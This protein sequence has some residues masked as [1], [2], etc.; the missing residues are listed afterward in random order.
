MHLAPHIASLGTETA[1]E[2]L[3][4]A[5]ALAARGRSVINLGIGQSDFPT[6]QHI[7][8]AGCRAL[9]DGHHGYTPANGILPLREAIAAD[10]HR[11]FGA[12][13]DPAQ[14]V[15]APGGKVTLAFALMMLG[16]PGVEVLTPDP[17]Y[18][19]Y[20]SMIDFSGATA[21]GYPPGGAGC[22]AFSADAILSR[23][24][25]RTRLLILNSPSN[26][27][28]EV[29]PRDELDRLVLGL[30]RHPNVYVLSDEIYSRLVFGRARHTSLLE[31]ES[32]RDRVI[33]LDGLS[34]TYAMSGWRVGWGIW[35]GNLA[36]VAARLAINIYSC[37][38][39]SA[40]HAGIAALQ[41]PQDDIARMVDTFAARREVLVPALDRLPGLS[42]K[43]PDG[44][45]FAF[46]DI[47]ATGFSA[48]ELQDRWLEELGVAVLAG[49]SFGSG[50]EGHVRISYASS[51]DELREALRRIAGW[52]DAHG[53][54]PLRS[55]A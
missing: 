15:V 49:T 20:R 46:P 11:R 43:R 25:A 40:Q 17:G 54:A 13:V 47:R 33:V 23:I 26:P 27:T 18:P 12:R 24:T 32:L 44:A 53:S 55:I 45:F 42:C 14:I 6:P 28:G 10:A 9:T 31:Y 21:I 34:K 36:E 2:V 8:E 16:Q 48:R 22:G 39:A 52:L 19:I 37:V 35:P 4:R 3:A 5:Q 1:F 51:L 38:N 29:V 50:G 30:Q 7:V 41:G